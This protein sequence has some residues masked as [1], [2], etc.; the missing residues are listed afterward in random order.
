MGNLAIYR[1]CEGD[2]LHS[3]ASFVANHRL[4]AARLPVRAV[5]GL[6][7]ASLLP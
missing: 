4:A 7:F 1:L 3:S 5:D 2:F 6:T